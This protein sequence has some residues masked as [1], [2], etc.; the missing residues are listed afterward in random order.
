VFNIVYDVVVDVEEKHCDVCITS[1][2][3]IE[4]TKNCAR[5]LPEDGQNAEFQA[6]LD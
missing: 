4:C 1:W 2:Q 6:N 5:I 3:S